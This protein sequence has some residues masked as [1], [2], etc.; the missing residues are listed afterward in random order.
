MNDIIVYGGIVMLIQ[1]S[2]K[3][4]LS[5]RDETILSLDSNKD[6]SHQENLLPFKN[7]RILPS[8]A[9]YGANAAGKSNLH[10]ALTAAILMVRNS[11]H[12]QVDQP[13]MVTPFLLDSS[14]RNE[15]TK[16]DFIYVYNG[17]KYEYGFT[18]D[19]KNV[20]EEYLYEYKSSK[21]SM[22]F[23][24]NEISKYKFTTKTRSQLSKIVDKNTSNKLFLATAT[25]WNSTL[26]KDAYMWF[27]NMID[28]YDSQN[29]EDLMFKEIDRFQKN[30]DH[31]LSQFMLRLLK[32]AD[33]NITDFNYKYTKK[34]ISQIPGLLPAE[35]QAFMNQM[36]NQNGIF[37]EHT[38]TTQHQVNEN[39]KIKT[40]PLSYFSESNGTKRLFS[41][42]PVL[43]NA[44]ETGKTIIIDE[45]DNALHPVMTKSLIE[46]FQN[47]NLNKHNA[48]LIFNTH[49]ICLLDL[50][51]FR[52]DQI[53][54]VEK[55]NQTGVSD[56]YSLDE[57]SPRKSE[58][59]QKGYL[60]GRYGAIPVVNLEDIEW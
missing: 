20:W 34:P 24:R 46:M 59:I 11:N 57:F 41:Y 2:V 31:S 12:L 44:L 39:G 3:N 29:L 36:P 40:Y 7:E 28:T 18:L 10:K 19:T 52:R 9:V 23:E 55:D 50:T 8:V 33:M 6:D 13:L 56:L 43:K 22:I 37:E 38:I 5:F 60:Q 21:P 32:N 4:F 58:N 54:F 17:V 1:F 47:P 14:S 35:L 16:F 45:I 49:E 27:A 15:K 30:N 51:L 48:Q 42:G 25:N 53:Y 26:T